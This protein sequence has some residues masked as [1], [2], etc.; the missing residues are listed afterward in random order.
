M[1]CLSLFWCAGVKG[2]GWGRKKESEIVSGRRAVIKPCLRASAGQVSH[3]A[4]RGAAGACC[5]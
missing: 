2:V 5:G 3:T 1:V 4:E